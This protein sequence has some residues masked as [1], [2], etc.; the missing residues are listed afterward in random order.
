MPNM[1]PLTAALS[2]L[3]VTAA[4]DICVVA[5]LFYQFIMIV[6]GRR[7]APILSGLGVLVLAYL[8][9]VWAGM[10]LLRTVLGN[11]ATYAGFAL[12]VVFQSEIRRMLARIG[13]RGWFGFGERLQSREFIDEILLA[14]GRMSQR[15]VGALVV[16]E[17]DIGLRTFVE[18]GVLID[19]AVSRDLLLAIFEPGGM[20]HDGA[21]IVQRDRIAAAACFLPLSMNMAISRKLGTRHRAAIGITEETDCLSLVVSEETGQISVVASGEIERDVTLKRVRERI[22][23]HFGGGQHSWQPPET[24]QR[25]TSRTSEEPSWHEEAED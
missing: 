11:L 8:M 21:V 2:K 7:A 13:R 20:L 5:F 16:L 12:I 19:A 22:V 10:E 6:R 18:S 25:E 3:S 23:E 9:A 24:P 14:L 15:S 17:R 4:I 1:T